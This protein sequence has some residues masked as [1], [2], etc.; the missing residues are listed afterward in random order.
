VAHGAELARMTDALP[1]AVRGL[2][3]LLGRRKV[4]SEVT[5]AFAPGSFNAVCGPNGAGKTTLLRAALG[6]VSPQA[7]E[8]RL[9]GEDPARLKP[10]ERARRIAYL[11]Q[12]RRVA[13]GL[14]ARAVAALGAPLS[15]NAEADD[16][17]LAALDRVGLLRLA[18]RGV[19]EMSGGERARVLLARLLVA[20]APVLVLDEPIAGLDPEAQLL[21]LDLLREEAA[22]G[23]TVVAT[24][25]DLCLAGRFANRVLVLDAGCLAADGPFLEALNREV[26][27]EV[28]RLDARWVETGAGDWLLASTRASASGRLS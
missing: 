21:T 2:S 19:F 18:D 4:L 24:L 12:E 23:A 9:F 17:A 6:L 14:P 28:F 7:G 22:K 8:V 27:A 26:L 1:L 16:H 15:P 3:V 20:E 11:P 13:W 10:A 25:H 5:A